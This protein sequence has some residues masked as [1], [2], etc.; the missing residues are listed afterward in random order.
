VR[1]RPAR[2][3]LTA[4]GAAL[5]VVLTGC[6][7]DP[8]AGPELVTLS[9]APTS[10]TPSS[11]GTPGGDLV[12]WF[13]RDGRLVPTTREAEDGESPAVLDLLAEGPTATEVSAGLGTA[14]LAQQPGLEVVDEDPTDP[15]VTVQVGQQ[16]LS[17][18]GTDQLPAVA[19]V[20][21]TVTELPGVE[22]VL[23]ATESGPLEVPTDDGL[24]AEAVQREDYASLAPE[25]TGGAP[26]PTRPAGAV[27]RTTPPT[28]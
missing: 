27:P 23:F 18:T 2:V 19:Q 15:L 11:T 24:T 5:G 22:E 21:W 1:R 28:G 10:A 25:A 17:L 16:F 20:V 3:L 12:L 26:T 8:Q 7:I 6:G 13:L 9:A 4:L 14:L